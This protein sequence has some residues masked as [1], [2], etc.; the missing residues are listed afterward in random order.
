M[1][2]ATSTPSDLRVQEQAPIQSVPDDIL[3]EIFIHS[4]PDEVTFATSEA[5]LLLCQIC[6][7]W[8]S[9]SISYAP[10]WTSL[11]LVISERDPAAVPG[12]EGF[13]TWFG[14]CKDSKIDFFL[15][16][17]RKLVW[18]DGSPNPPLN[19]HFTFLSRSLAHIPSY[20]FRHLTL[21]GVPLQVVHSLPQ[22]ALPSLERLVLAFT[23]HETPIDWITDGPIRAFEQCPL[24]RRV[25]LDGVCL[26]PDLRNTLAISWDQL[27]HFFYLCELAPED[28]VHCVSKMTSLVHGCFCLGDKTAG[29]IE[30]PSPELEVSPIRKMI[31]LH[32]LSSLTLS[33]WDM[34]RGEVD[35]PDFW[36]SFDF[37]NLRTLRI[38]GARCA[39]MASAG[40]WDDQR[41]FLAN[42]KALERLEKLSLSIG[43]LNTHDC[44]TLF[45]SCPNVTHL[46]LDTS[47]DQYRA[48]LMA[49]D[50]DRGYL[51][52]LKALALEVGYGSAFRKLY[53]EGLDDDDIVQTRALLSMVESRR[54]CEPQGQLKRIVFYGAEPWQVSDGKEF[55]KCLGPYIEKGL[56]IEHKVEKEIGLAGLGDPILFGRHEQLSD[57][58]EAG[59][60]FRNN[61]EDP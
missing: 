25:A 60:V 32:E 13:F 30:P 21:H 31:V 8:R 18:F 49:L 10:L 24:L 56:I 1:N 55:H 61:Y 2:H 27:T 17:R 48:A 57:W 6:S 12:E 42:L 52:K 5:P 45:Q 22:G 3:H 46:D 34:P 29:D 28:Y 50:G 38:V 4:L 58:R 41:Y 19:Y 14:R 36:R 37:P 20:T 53:I 7:R 40:Y 44:E 26:A 15:I 33:Y 51:P 16:F 35:Y 54:P 11:K 9:L 47:N 43:E 39:E 59:D 23:F